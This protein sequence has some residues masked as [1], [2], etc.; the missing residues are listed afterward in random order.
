ML[1][2]HVNATKRETG[3]G[4]GGGARLGSRDLEFARDATAQPR[5]LGYSK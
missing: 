3:G 1:H 2:V 4:G 5:A